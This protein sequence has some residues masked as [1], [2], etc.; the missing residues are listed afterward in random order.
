MDEPR[1]YHQ[2]C[3]KD[4][5]GNTTW[6]GRDLNH[7][8]VRLERDRQPALAEL[9]SQYHIPIYLRKWRRLGTTRDETRKAVL[10]VLRTRR[11]SHLVIETYTWPLLEKEE[12]LVHGIAREFRWLLKI[13]AELGIERG[14]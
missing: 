13:L 3:G 2:F 4:I 8:P 12:R 6:R 9:R 7:L 10:E 5:D 1:Y 11:C 14:L